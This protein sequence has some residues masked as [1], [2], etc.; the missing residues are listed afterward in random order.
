MRS[1]ECRSNSLSFHR[2]NV[3]VFVCVYSCPLHDMFIPI[4]MPF[5]FLHAVL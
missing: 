4:L 3:S 2:C 1:T 5:V